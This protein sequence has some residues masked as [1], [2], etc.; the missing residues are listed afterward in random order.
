VL[1]VELGP[2][3]P[4]QLQPLGLVNEGNTCYVVGRRCG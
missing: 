3:M 1:E 2:A 4:A